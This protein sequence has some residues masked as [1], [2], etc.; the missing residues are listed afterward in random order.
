[1]LGICNGFQIPCEA[2]LL[3]VR[4]VAGE[5]TCSAT[6]RIRIRLPVSFRRE[7]PW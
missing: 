4:A 1:M 2:H 5:P 3:P 6:A 7:K